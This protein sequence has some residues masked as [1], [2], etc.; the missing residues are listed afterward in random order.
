MNVHKDRFAD[1]DLVGRAQAGDI[2][3]FTEL[4]GLIQEKVYHTI[5]GMTRNQED[6]GDLTQETF[7]YAYRSLKSFKRQSSFYTWVYRIAVNLTLNFLKKKGREKGTESFEDKAAVFDK[8]GYEALSP[9]GDS[10]LRELKDKINE[11][12]AAL[13]LPYR[14]A[15]NLVV[16]QGLSHGQ[17]AEILGCSENT[18]SWRMHKA[19]KMLQ[20]K[21]GPY[22]AEA[23]DAL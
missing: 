10:L 4:A 18:V 23:R 16:F 7:M 22:M 1:D 12:I 11:A 9:E 15:F 5:L 2:E 17:A 20:A 21:L 8:A 14:A 13:S 6:A 3:A 19:R